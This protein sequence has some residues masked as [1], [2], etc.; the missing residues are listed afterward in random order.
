[1]TDRIFQ[2]DIDPGGGGGTPLCY[3]N[4]DVRPD[5]VWF[6]GCFFLNWVSIS[7]LSFLNRVSLHDLMA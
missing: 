5:R 1:M 2:Y 4:G 3:L 7:S 6:S